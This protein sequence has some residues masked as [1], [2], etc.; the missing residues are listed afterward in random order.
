MELNLSEKYKP[1]PVE[2]VTRKVRSLDAEKALG[3]GSPKKDKRRMK[4]DMAVYVDKDPELRSMHRHAKQTIE[5]RNKQKH[6]KEL[7]ELY[8]LW[9]DEQIR[10]LS[11]APK[12]EIANADPAHIGGPNQDNINHPIIKRRNQLDSLR[13]Q[14]MDPVSAHQAIHGEVDPASTESKA[15]FAASLGRIQ[16]DG[17]RNAVTLQPEKGSILSR[18]AEVEKKLNQTT[19]DDLRTP[20]NQQIPD[21]EQTP[22]EQVAE[23]LDLQEDYDYNLDVAYLQ[24]FGRA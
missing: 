14:G 12:P 24:K 2:K 3:M 6:Y 19:H 7:E 10:G 5:K 13:A 11:M 1:F 8:N 4:M 18:D 16:D 20:M 21:K 15:D 9:E 17:N 23:E 22:G